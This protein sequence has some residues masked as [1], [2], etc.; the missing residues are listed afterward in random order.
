M[1]NQGGKQAERRRNAQSRREASREKLKCTIKEGSKHRGV[2]THTQ[3]GSEQRDVGM[4]NQ[5]V[6]KQ[7]MK[8][9]RTIK[10]G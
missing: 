3:K 6:S 1:H 8:E 10:E 5:G 4:H 2:G 7:Q 9:G